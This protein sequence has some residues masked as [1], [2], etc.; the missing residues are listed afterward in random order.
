MRTTLKRGLGRA[1]ANGSG[2][3]RPVFPPG[4]ITPMRRYRQP[5]PPGRGTFATVRLLFFWGFVSILIVVGGIAGGAYLFFHREVSNVRRIRW[6]SR[7]PPRSSTWHSPESR[8][9]RL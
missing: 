1:A 7:S 8:P 2:N 4:A 5:P 9:R 6:R 3:G